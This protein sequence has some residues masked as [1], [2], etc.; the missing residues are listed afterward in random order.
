MT[1]N[2]APATDA[3]FALAIEANNAITALSTIITR[4]SI[5]DFDLEYS[6]KNWF[7]WFNYFDALPIVFRALRPLY[8]P[9]D[10]DFATPARFPS[11]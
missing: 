5:S 9:C 4:K 2:I 7:D 8:A 6:I 10:F 11:N 3:D 1:N